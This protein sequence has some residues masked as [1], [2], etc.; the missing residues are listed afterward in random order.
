MLELPEDYTL[1]QAYNDI[2]YHGKRQIAFE[3]DMENELAKWKE[4]TVAYLKEQGKATSE[5]SEFLTAELLKQ[6]IRIHKDRLSLGYFK[7]SLSAT[8]KR[9]FDDMET[10]TAKVKGLFKKDGTEYVIK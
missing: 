3:V 9:T 2:I 1:Q 7:R 4:L 6:G 5:W 10:L 8:H